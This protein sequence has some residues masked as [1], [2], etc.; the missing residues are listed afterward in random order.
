MYISIQCIS[1]WR[2]ESNLWKLVLSSHDEDPRDR[3]QAVWQAVD[4]L[5]CWAI[6]LALY[7]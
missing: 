1:L 3:T 2:W 7:M 4:T 5:S 6:F